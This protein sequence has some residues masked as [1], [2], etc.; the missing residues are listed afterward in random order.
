MSK[1]V[2]DPD[3][4]AKLN[5]L[6]EQI[7]FCDESGKTLGRF[8]PE[9]EYRRMQY[10]LAE[11]LCP[12]SQEELERMRQEKGGRPLADLWKELGVS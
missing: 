7:E 12:Y 6:N 4:R 10:A 8:V 9:E 5:G 11:A 2:L 1:Y 3:L